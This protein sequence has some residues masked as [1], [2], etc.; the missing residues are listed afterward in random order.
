MALFDKLQPLD[1]DTYSSIHRSEK[2]ENFAFAIP[3]KHT[4]NVLDEAIEQHKK[5]PYRIIT[6]LNVGNYK[7][8]CNNISSNEEFLYSCSNLSEI[9]NDDWFDEFY[10]GN[11]EKINGGLYQCLSIFTP[12]VRFEKENEKHYFNVLTCFL[13]NYDLCKSNGIDDETFNKHYRRRINYIYNVLFREKQDILITDEEAI[14]Q[15]G[16]DKSKAMMMFLKE[17]TMSTIITTR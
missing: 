17:C 11:N 1:A 15:F 14:A 13:P 9:L 12:D 5:N 16:L 8:P 10:K 3:V 6:I 7:S 2:Y 4:N